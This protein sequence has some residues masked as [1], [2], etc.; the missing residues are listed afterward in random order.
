M[1]LGEQT[2]GASAADAATAKID[3][4]TNK[5]RELET[6]LGRAFAKN[7]K[8]ETQLDHA[9]AQVAWFQRNLFGQK[10]ERVDTELLQGAWREFLKAQ[11]AAARGDAPPLPEPS[12]AMQLLLMLG[13]S[14]SGAPPTTTQAAL[15]AAGVPAPRSIMIEGWP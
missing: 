10:R 4:L 13:K 8:L 14:E 12:N 11:E 2:V 1:T 6:S 3:T 9:R 15:D 7:A 5:I